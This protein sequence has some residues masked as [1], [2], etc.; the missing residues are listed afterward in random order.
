[1]AKQDYM[2]SDEIL[3][4]ADYSIIGNYFSVYISVNGVTINFVTENLR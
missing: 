3:N 1:M 4:D 2:L